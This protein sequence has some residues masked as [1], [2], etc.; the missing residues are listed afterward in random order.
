MSCE[1][2]VEVSMFGKLATSHAPWIPIRIFF[3]VLG[4]SS[5]DLDT[6]LIT[7]VIVFVPSGSG[8]GT[9]SKWPFMAEIKG[10]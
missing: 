9:P 6:W 8:C 1:V 4:G 7:M 10:G 2:E 5:H 3:P